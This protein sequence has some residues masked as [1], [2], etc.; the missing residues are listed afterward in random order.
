MVPFG[1][2][3]NISNGD[4]SP[5][6]GLA[7]AVMISLFTDARAPGPDALPEG[8]DSLR[9]WWGDL[10][11]FKTGS[12]LWTMAREK[13]LPV[14]A[15]KAR[16]YCIDALAWIKSQGIASEIQVEADIVRPFGLE[17]KIR[18]YRGDSKRYAY[19]WDAIKTYESVTV[20][21]T[22]I[23]IDFIE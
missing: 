23:S 8:E 10:D 1:A 16:E 12:L 13:V 22:G 17:I 7:T 18:I 11:T 5:D 14:T 19:L 6:N 9:G 15:A 21:N 2:D 20:Q 4:L 3:I